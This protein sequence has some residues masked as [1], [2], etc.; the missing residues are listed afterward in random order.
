MRKQCEMRALDCSLTPGPVATSNA[1]TVSIMASVGR[2]SLRAREAQLP[3][4]SSAIGVDLVRKIGARASTGATEALCLGPDEWQILTAEA[5][6]RRLTEACA[7]IY[8]EAPHSLT[9]ISGR[10]ISVR[11]EGPKAAELLT[12]GCPRDIDRLAEGEGRRTLMD[13]ATVVLWRDGMASFRLDVWRSFAPDVIALL[14]IG[15]AELAAE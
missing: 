3:V 11:I 2:F 12:L 8:P 10:E 9:D 4:L 1:A 14:L 15:C 5:D 7:R 6:A 13:R